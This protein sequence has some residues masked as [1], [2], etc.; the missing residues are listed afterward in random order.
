LRVVESLPRAVREIEH[1]W[2][3]LA[4]G[5]RL[6]ARMWLPEGAEAHP[7]PTVFEYIPYGKRDGTRERH[8]PIHRYCAGHG[9]AS[10]RVDLRG[11]GEAATREHPAGRVGRADRKTPLA[12]ANTIK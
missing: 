2:I 8:E 12:G 4:D 1:C 10:L 3:P 11:S 7:V 6:A 5:T 9:Y